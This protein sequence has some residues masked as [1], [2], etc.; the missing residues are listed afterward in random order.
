M[1]WI[2]LLSSWGF[3]GLPKFPVARGSSDFY[4][5]DDKFPLEACRLILVSLLE[6]H[7]I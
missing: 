4:A 5:I 7:I 6:T 1:L 3:L 2:L